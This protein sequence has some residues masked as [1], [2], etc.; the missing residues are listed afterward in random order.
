MSEYNE[1]IQAIG[2]CRY[3]ETIKESYESSLNTLGNFYDYVEEM[4]FVIIG[5]KENGYY[6][7]N[8][9]T[10]YRSDS[11]TKESEAL[12]HLGIILMRESQA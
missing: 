10:K 3:L 8:S 4:G 1:I 7:E 5:N 6:I 12:T 9:R 11:F 2:A